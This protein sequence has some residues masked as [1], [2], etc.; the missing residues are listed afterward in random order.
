[1]IYMPGVG[2]LPYMP[3]IRAIQ[4]QIRSNYNNPNKSNKPSSPNALF[5]VEIPFISS[6]IHISDYFNRPGSNL[7]NPANLTYPNDPKDPNDP[8]DPRMHR[9]KRARYNDLWVIKAIK[10]ESI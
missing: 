2:I 9:D 3:I 7:Q 8:N 4:A 10:I 6:L 1:M 5:V